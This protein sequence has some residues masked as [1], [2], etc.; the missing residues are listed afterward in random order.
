MVGA[1]ICGNRSLFAKVECTLLHAASPGGRGLALV[2][3]SAACNICSQGIAGRYGTVRVAH[4][5]FVRPLIVRGGRI[6]H[7]SGGDA[8]GQVRHANS[9]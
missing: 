5:R 4:V 8:K 3:S 1:W 2:V 9:R 7:R 6:I